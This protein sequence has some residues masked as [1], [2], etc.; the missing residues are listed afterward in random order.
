MSLNYQQLVPL[1]LDA[2]FHM[3]IHSAKKLWAY[4]KSL[5]HAQHLFIQQV[6]SGRYIALI[7]HQNS[8]QS[9]ISCRADQRL[10]R[11]MVFPFRRKR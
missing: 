4:F 8:E 1:T 2:C 7:D 5:A 6:S 3:S 9:A 10:R 11:V